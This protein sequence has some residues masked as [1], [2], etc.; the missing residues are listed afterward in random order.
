[1]PPAQLM[2]AAAA[3]AGNGMQ[4]IPQQLMAGVKSEQEANALKAQLLTAQ[5][6]PA[7]LSLL[8]QVGGNP[9][10]AEALAALGPQA[11]QLGN[12]AALQAMI[13]DGQ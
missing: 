3:T 6:N 5:Q 8:S 11:A 10:G 4:G 7:L 9:A 2:A 12:V 13:P 1:M